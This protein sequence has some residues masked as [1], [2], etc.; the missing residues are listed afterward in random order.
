MTAV[1]LTVGPGW[2]DEVLR[3]RAAR[4]YPSAVRMT[5]TGHDAEDLVQET[6]ARAV[7]ASAQFQPGTNPGAWLHRIRINVYIGPVRP[8]LTVGSRLKRQSP[9]GARQGGQ[10]NG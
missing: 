4:L 8:A 2:A 5:G 9:P 7:A 3:A 1:T 6:F 10:D